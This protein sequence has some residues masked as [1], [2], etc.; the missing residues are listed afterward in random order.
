MTYFLGMHPLT[1]KKIDIEKLR[2]GFIVYGASSRTDWRKIKIDDIQFN[3]LRISKH[4]NSN[5]E[6]N[7][8]SK[9]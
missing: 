4:V 2:L 5:A 9:A 6:K 3:W 7:R 1:S 8:L